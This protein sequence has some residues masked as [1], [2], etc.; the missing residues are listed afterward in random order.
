MTLTQKTINDL[1]TRETDGVGVS[2]GDLAAILCQLL[3]PAEVPVRFE[4]AEQVV[5][6]VV[7]GEVDRAG[8]D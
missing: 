2:P 7:E 5:S 1:V 8:A 6:V 3:L 4:G